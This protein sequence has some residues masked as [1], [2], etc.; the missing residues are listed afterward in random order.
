MSEPEALEKLRNILF[1]RGASEPFELNFF[2]RQFHRIIKFLNNEDFLPYEIEIQP[3]SQ[4]NVNCSL[5]WGEQKRLPNTLCKQDNL[6]KILQMILKA[7][8]SFR[9][10]FPKS[11]L[12]CEFN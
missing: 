8:E 10:A 5:C 11:R 1:T 4:C 9:G 2:R 7:N 3:S 12:C 6:K